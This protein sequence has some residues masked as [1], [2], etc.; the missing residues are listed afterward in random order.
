VRRSRLTY[1]LWTV[2]LFVLELGI[3]L[4][5]HDRF[6][7]PF[8][9]DVL[10]VLLIYCALQTVFRAPSRLMAVL[11]LALAFGVECLQ[12]VD[13]AAWLGVDR[14]PWLS[15]ALGR[16]FAWDDFLAYL[17]GYWVLHR[18]EIAHVAGG[19]SASPPQ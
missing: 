7:R 18:V 3:A 1:A 9:G 15:V 16:T 17:A 8:L 14:I 12:A 19:T 13:Y 11:V 4:F 2:G 6:V 5:V 10:V